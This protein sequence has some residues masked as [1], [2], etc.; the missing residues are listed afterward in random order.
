MLKQEKKRKM[1]SYRVLL[2][3]SG[4]NSVVTKLDGK[5]LYSLLWDTIVVPKIM[6]HVN[7]TRLSTQ[8]TILNS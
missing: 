6:I 8:H 5:T 4:V 7:I 3:H 2:R 1:V